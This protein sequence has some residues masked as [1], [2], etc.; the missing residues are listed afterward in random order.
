MHLSANSTSSPSAGPGG[1]L[2]AWLHA[3]QRVFDRA[4]PPGQAAA[5]ALPSVS[6]LSRNASL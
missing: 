6:S 5:Q 2:Q 4:N 1:S 3:S